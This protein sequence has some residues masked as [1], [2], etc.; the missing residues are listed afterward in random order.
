MDVK[1]NKI[2]QTVK[3][4]IQKGDEIINNF[5][6]CLELLSLKTSK[7]TEKCSLKTQYSEN[8]DID[9]TPKLLK[10]S[11]DIKSLEK[12]V[13]ISRNELSELLRVPYS[14]K[15]HVIFNE[16][17]IFIKRINDSGILQKIKNLNISQDEGKLNNPINYLKNKIKLLS[18]K[19]STISFNDYDNSLEINSIFILVIDEL[20][21]LLICDYDFEINDLLK[22]IE[23]QLNQEFEF[24]NSDELSI[25]FIQIYETLIKLKENIKCEIVDVLFEDI[26]IQPEIKLD[27]HGIKIQDK[28]QETLEISID[29]P[30]KS[31]VLKNF[32]F[33]GN[34]LLS[35]K[36]KSDSSINGSYI[37]AEE[38]QIH[39]SYI[40]AE[41]QPSKKRRDIG[42][43]PIT[44]PPPPPS[45]KEE[46]FG[47]IS[48][49]E[50][51]I[52]T[53]VDQLK[54]TPPRPPHPP[55]P[56][57]PRKCDEKQTYIHLGP[58][59]IKSKTQYVVKDEF[60]LP[61][62][63]AETETSITESRI[64]NYLQ[65]NVDL[66]PPSIESKTQYVV[67]D[68][69][70]LPHQTAETETSIT[71][72]RIENYLQKNVDILQNGNKILLSPY[73]CSPPSFTPPPIPK[74][75]YYI[76]ENYEGNK[77]TLKL[78]NAG[79]LVEIISY[80]DNLALCKR[81]KNDK[82][83]YLPIDILLNLNEILIL[84]SKIDEKSKVQLK[85]NFYTP[86]W[87]TNWI[88]KQGSEVILL[89]DC[90]TDQTIVSCLLNGF[91]K[92]ELPVHILD[93]FYKKT[94]L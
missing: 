61:H 51:F 88:L 59:S 85:V 67:K 24:S 46:Q 12:R 58:P 93:F 66:G 20:N 7:L 34:L 63:T 5:K 74:S 54:N 44:S 73:I 1:R 26:E 80:L 83:G 70:D 28:I 52:F 87:E 76:I 94:T 62:Q 30:V 32:W 72:S 10:Y 47:G 25:F 78:V 82:I 56:P 9:L 2:E 18:K 33:N 27:T 75:R 53:Q 90:D 14:C 65:K 36:L 91:I 50:E 16:I 77:N 92:L 19:L 31:K 38:F 40:K 42:P 48:I 71:E 43:C 22:Y 23:E 4:D 84:K 45:K 8:F 55:P 35:D 89:E 49:D 39:E 21:N 6:S 64:E 29:H 86:K 81:L 79:E 41:S 60:D 13:R 15:K 11:K 37:K 69:F 3:D 57:P 68:E 17:N